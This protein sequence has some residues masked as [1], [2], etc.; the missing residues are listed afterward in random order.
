MYSVRCNKQNKEASYLL[1]LPIAKF[2]VGFHLQ[3]LPNSSKTI[4]DSYILGLTI[5]QQTPTQKNVLKTERISAC[6]RFGKI[7]QQKAQA[8]ERVWKGTQS[9]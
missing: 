3:T 8:R 4:A 7:P 9:Q 6:F 5:A 1:G 2:M